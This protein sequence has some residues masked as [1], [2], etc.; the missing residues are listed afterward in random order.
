MQD[1]P[2]NIRSGDFFSDINIRSG[3]CDI[4]KGASGYVCKTTIHRYHIHRCI[5]PSKI[6]TVGPTNIVII[7]VLIYLFIYTLKENRT[8]GVT[9][10]QHPANTPRS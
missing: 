5:S 8:C 10:R 7:L 1:N 2:H 6:N 4:L 9:T 3:D